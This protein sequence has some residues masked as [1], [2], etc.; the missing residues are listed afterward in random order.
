MLTSGGVCLGSTVPSV[1][2]RGEPHVG[3][4]LKTLRISAFFLPLL[5]W[6]ISPTQDL[7]S[8]GHKR[9]GQLPPRPAAISLLSGMR[10][11]RW[12]PLSWWKR[13]Y[14]GTWPCGWAWGE[15]GLGAFLRREGWGK[16][17][18]SSETGIV[19]TCAMMGPLHGYFRAAVKK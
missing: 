15:A 3:L 10:P 2:T 12:V 18:F 6:L 13:A 1:G 7:G 9:A 5:I 14:N 4:Q 11:G 17:L 8:E 16:K 19:A